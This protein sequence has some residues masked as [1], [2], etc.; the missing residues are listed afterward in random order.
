MARKNNSK[1]PEET[2]AE[3]TAEAPAGSGTS[4]VFAGGAVIIPGPTLPKRDPVVEKASAEESD[5]EP[6]ASAPEPKD[7]RV[8]SEHIVKT[9]GLTSSQNRMTRLLELSR[10][11]R[12]VA[13]LLAEYQAAQKTEA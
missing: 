7:V 11:N 8:T 3:T 13:W 12:D 10:T 6:K 9:L 4:R 2:T 5:D 1:A